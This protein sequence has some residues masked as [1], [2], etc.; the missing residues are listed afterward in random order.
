MLRFV[1]VNKSKN[2][3][4]CEQRSYIT[5]DAEVPELEKRLK[6][7]GYDQYHYDYTDLVGVEIL[8]PKNEGE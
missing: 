5:I 7:G 3:D 1:L 8:Y 2:T 6:M 4:S